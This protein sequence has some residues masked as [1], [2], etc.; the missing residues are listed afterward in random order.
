MRTPPGRLRDHLGPQAEHL[1]QQVR[2]DDI[3]GGSL[4]QDAA[5]LVLQADDITFATSVSIQGAHAVLTELAEK[6]DVDPHRSA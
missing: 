3:G 4:G 1:R 5:I 2:G 6:Y